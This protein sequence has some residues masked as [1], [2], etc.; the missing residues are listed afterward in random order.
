VLRVT[1]PAPP[2]EFRRPIDTFFTSLAESQEDCAVGIILSGTGSDGSAGIKAVK[3][4]GGFTLAQA[5]FDEHAMSGMPQSAASTGLVDVVESV[6]GLPAKLLEHQEHLARVENQKDADGVRED[7]KE[8]LTAI[9][10]LLRKRLKHDFSGYKQ[11]TM[12]RRIQRRMQVLRIEAV[13]DYA[14]HLRREPSEGDALF[15]ELLIG[16][17]Q[18]F[19]DEDA[20]ETLKTEILPPLLAT[21]AADDPIRVWV[22][23]CATGE[24]VYSIA[25]VLEEVLA[26]QKSRVPVTIFGTDIDAKAIAVARAAR[27]RRLD[28][29]SAERLQRW[30]VK[31]GDSWCPVAA[32]RD[33]C[34][35]SEHSLVK[36]PPFSKLDL[37][38]CRNVLIYLD[39]ELQQ[40]L[41]QTFHYAL[42]PGG[43][44]FLGPS[45]SVS[46][47]TKSFGVAHKKHRILQRHDS[48]KSPGD[49]PAFAGLVCH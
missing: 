44:L 35:F 26:S 48:I 8:S 11:N 41:I 31:D 4:F 5:Q 38:S 22:A 2:R 21:R 20:F 47:T 27:Y 28:G 29:L 17:T 34:I 40:Q 43:Y 36:D 7:V 13:S 32:I 46:R 24:E 23:G 10:V 45:E 16:V 19:R 42:R 15:R 39:N 33:L 12:I 18:F 9:I 25:I 6:E 1:T 30:F 37:V 49:G 3:A 14:E